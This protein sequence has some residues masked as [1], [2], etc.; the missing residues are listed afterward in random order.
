[1]II[2]T[3]N[4][5]DYILEEVKVW[6]EFHRLFPT[7]LI[8]ISN[9]KHSL[10]NEN[11]GQCYLKGFTFDNCYEIEQ[12]TGIQDKNGT[13]IYEGDIIYNS[14][15]KNSDEGEYVVATYILVLF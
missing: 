3:Y 10:N 9:P 1:M 7:E 11:T 15:I 13:D 6:E 5:K 8:L 2:F 14:N 4:N 12:F